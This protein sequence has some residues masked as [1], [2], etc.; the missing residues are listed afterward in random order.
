VVHHQYYGVGGQWPSRCEIKGRV[1]GGSKERSIY[2]CSSACIPSTVQRFQPLATGT[3]VQAAA[4]PVPFEDFK[5]GLPASASEQ[6]REAEKDDELFSMLPSKMLGDSKLCCY[7]GFWLSEVFLKGAVALEH[8]FAPPPD[9][10]IVASLPK[11]GTTWVIA[12]T[13]ATMV[14]RV[15]PANAVDH[16]LRRLNP[17]QCLPFLETLFS[18]GKEAMLDALPSPRLMNTH[19]PLD[20]IPRAVGSQGCKV[21]YV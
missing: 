20:F 18:D 7:K 1:F 6:Q 8:R 3:P 13:V 11:C 4:G 14:R 9:D 15:Y 10:V 19:M 12:L 2:T 21:V 5:A 17:H 16:P